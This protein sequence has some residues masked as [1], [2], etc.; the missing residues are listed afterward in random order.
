[1]NVEHRGLCVWTVR[2]KSKT[3]EQTQ[4]SET[5]N[6]TTKF[7]YYKKT[8]KIYICTGDKIN[9][10][11]KVEKSKIKKFKTIYRNNSKDFKGNPQLSTKIYNN[12]QMC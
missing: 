3:R 4:N 10:L 1:M 9:L 8:E 12:P 5:K 2:D 7:I 6:L 11:Q